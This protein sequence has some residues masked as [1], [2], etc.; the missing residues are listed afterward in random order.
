MTAV[1]TYLIVLVI[2]GSITITT[3]LADTVNVNTYPY[4]IPG[5]GNPGL[6][7]ASSG[8]VGIGTTGPAAKLDLGTN[9]GLFLGGFTNQWGFDVNV[10]DYGGGNVPL[11]FISRGSGINNEVMRITHGGYVGIGN[12]NPQTQL[13]IGSINAGSGEATNMGSIQIATAGG[14]TNTPGG[15]EFKTSSYQN[16]YGWRITAPDTYGSAGTPLTIQDRS[17]SAGWTEIMRI[18]NAGNV[19]IGTTSP[20]QK[21]DVSGNIRLTGNMTSPNDI[22]IGTC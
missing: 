20:A 21:L 14:L 22:C 4:Q 17:N 7:V 2:L 15:L 16:G 18:T 11:M 1:N 6:N 10:T 12:T 13:S 9:P 19:G 8:N 3:V 5:S